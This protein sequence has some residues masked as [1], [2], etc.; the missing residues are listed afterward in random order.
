MQVG[1]RAT[2][3]TCPTCGGAIWDDQGEETLAF[4]CRIGHRF[5]LGAMLADHA[6]QHRETLGT[7]MRYTAEA[8]ALK[9]LIAGW[10][11]THGHSLAAE[12]LDEEADTLDST[13]REIERVAGSAAAPLTPSGP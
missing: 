7:A 6:A 10:A 12:R 2:G 1:E 9:R 3:I 8:A 4:H 13:A 5:S 11:R